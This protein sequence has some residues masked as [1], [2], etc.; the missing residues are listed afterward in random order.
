MGVVAVW[1]D[2]AGGVGLGVELA[3]LI[4]CVF[5][6]VCVLDIVFAQTSLLWKAFF[7]ASTH[8]IKMI[9]VS[10]QHHH[11]SFNAQPTFV[12]Q[13]VDKAGKPYVM[14]MSDNWLYA[15]ARGLKDAG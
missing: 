7:I 12:M 3:Q 15:G 6:N 5:L 10:F 8:A 2:T 1:L 13:L 14:L 9:F 4:V 11:K